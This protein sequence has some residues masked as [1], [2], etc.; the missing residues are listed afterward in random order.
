MAP[1]QQLPTSTTTSQHGQCWKAGTEDLLHDLPLPSTFSW[2]PVFRQSAMFLSKDM[3]D[4][5]WIHQVYVLVGFSCIAPCLL[6]QEC[7]MLSKP[8]SLLL[9]AF[10][11]RLEIPLGSFWKIL[12][13]KHNLLSCLWTRIMLCTIKKP[14]AGLPASLPGTSH[15]STVSWKHISSGSLKDTNLLVPAF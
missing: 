6:D 5:C 15:Q 1:P 11:W 10:F 9:C 7:G 14:E 2:F 13:W 4:F 12:Q 3:R 8:I